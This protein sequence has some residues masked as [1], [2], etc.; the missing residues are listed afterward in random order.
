MG[1]GGSRAADDGNLIPVLSGRVMSNQ[2]PF[3]VK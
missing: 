2:I 3:V 1:A